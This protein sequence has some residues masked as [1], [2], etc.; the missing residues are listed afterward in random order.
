MQSGVKDWRYIVFV[1][2]Q[3]TGVNG[4]QTAGRPENIMPLSPT[5]GG[6]GIIMKNLQQKCLTW[7]PHSLIT[8]MLMSST[9]TVIF[10]PAG[11]PY[12]VPMRLST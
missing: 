5:V 3:E 11:G 9:N 6:G 8:G 2:S 12:V 4:Q 7:S 10:L 1:A